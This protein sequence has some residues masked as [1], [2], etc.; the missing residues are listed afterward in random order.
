MK[1]WLL[2]AFAIVAEVTATSCLKLSK[3]FTQLWPSVVVVV[4]YAAAFYTLSIVAQKMDISVIYA[5]W[6]GLGIAILALVG[7]FY[8]KEP[9]TLVRALGLL[10]IALGVAL[11]KL[12]SPSSG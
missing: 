10:L 6:S 3:G 5:V 9:L 12:S 8:F 2:L 11:L 4:G 7:T 1:L